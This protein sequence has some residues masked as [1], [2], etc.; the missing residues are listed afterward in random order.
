[1]DVFIASGRS[2]ISL[3]SHTSWFDPAHQPPSDAVFEGCSKAMGNGP[4]DSMDSSLPL[5]DVGRLLP[6]HAEVDVIIVTS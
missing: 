5:K 2:I 4:R 6:L 1:M 3:C